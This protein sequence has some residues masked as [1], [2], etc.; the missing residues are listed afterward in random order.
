MYDT[1]FAIVLGWL[2][3]LL[4][5]TIAERI[6][7]PYRRRE[8]TRAVVNKMLALQ[9]TMV[10]LECRIRIRRRDLSVKFL[11][12]A[13]PVLDGFQ[14]PGKNSDYIAGIKKVR[15]MSDAQRVEFCRT[16]SDPSIGLG[17]PQYSLPLFST[18]IANLAVC[19]IDFQRSVLSV[20]YH[21]DLYNQ[22]SLRAQALLDMT[23]NKPSQEDRGAIIKNLESIY[24]GIGERAELVM[25]LIG[26]LRT[27]F[28]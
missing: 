3:G 1:I 25:H 17:L 15:E 16:V 2:L 21:L 23:F 5:P 7:R 11:D 19:G 27:R 18:Q 10:V 12:S 9:H 14:G 24:A 28:N 8:L 22:S 13:F 26:D 6:R 4:S 20:K